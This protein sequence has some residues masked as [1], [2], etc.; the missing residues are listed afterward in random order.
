MKN[1]IFTTAN[2]KSTRL[3]NSKNYKGHV[4]EKVAPRGVEYYTVDKVGFFLYLKDAKDAID[5]M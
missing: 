1:I 5:N 3:I 2:G 4:I